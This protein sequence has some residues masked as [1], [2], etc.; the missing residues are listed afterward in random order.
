MAIEY[1]PMVR[2]DYSEAYALWKRCEGI[3]LSNADS[4]CAISAFLVRNPEMSFIARKDGKLIGTG[5]CG[6]DGRR[7]YLYHLAVDPEYR[8]EG[9][10]AELASRCL[11]A[12]KAA[13]IGKCHI[14]VFKDNLDGQKFWE[15]TGWILRS[16]LVVM[17][18]EINSEK[19]SC[20]C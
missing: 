11:A 5:L 6:S 20:P 4:E 18:A 13:G 10:G 15:K 14:M 2:E 8:R 19:D 17:S 16:D 12:L 3:G 1:F 9:T 7:G